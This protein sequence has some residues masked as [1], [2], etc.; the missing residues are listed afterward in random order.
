MIR[1]LKT[2]VT[3]LGFFDQGMYA[4]K[5]AEVSRRCLIS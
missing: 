2:F 3:W 4:G 5:E 1:K